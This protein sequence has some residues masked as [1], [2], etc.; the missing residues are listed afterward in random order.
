MSSTT[1]AANVSGGDIL[2]VYDPDTEADAHVFYV[3]SV[4]SSSVTAVNG[5][6]GGAL[7]SGTTDL[8]SAL[9]EQN[10]LA[11]GYEI[12]EAI[13]TIIANQLWPWVYD[14]V[15]ATIASPDI[16]TGQEAVPAEV[17]EITTAW[18]IIG[19]H[20]VLIPVSRQPYVVHTT[21]AATGKLAHFDWINASAGYYT[22][23]AKYVEA[24]E[25]DTELTHL[26]ATGAAAILL[27]AS[28]S[29][30]TLESTKKDNVEAVGQRSSAGD[31]LWRDFLTLRQNMSEELGRRLPQ[32]ILFNRG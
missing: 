20:N 19:P 22:Y 12:F 16:T 6:D 23:R 10:P 9:F 14:E 27:G 28:L 7:V 18:Q 4:S 30:T 21:L 32:Q 31:R 11:T 1:E 24:D 29:E 25:L 26:I 8:D 3:L 17:E 2:S 13:D 5:Y 15:T